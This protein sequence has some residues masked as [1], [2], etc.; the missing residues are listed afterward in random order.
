[1][2]QAYLIL[3]HVLLLCLIAKGATRKLFAPPSPAAYDTPHYRLELS[4]HARKDSLVPTNA[5]V[6]LGDSHI[7]GMLTTAVAEPSV[8]FG[9]GGDTTDGIINRL[10][11]YECLARA[12][13]VV[14]LVGINDMVFRSNE[15]ALQNYSALLGA[16]PKGK[17]AAIGVLPVREGALT[18]QNKSLNN[19][20]ISAFN[21]ELQTICKAK[22]IRYIEPPTDAEYESDGVHLSAS[23]YAVFVR[24]LQ[25]EL[26]RIGVDCGNNQI[27]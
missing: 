26:G 19:E 3:L 22:G 5:V 14:L 21:A 20:R 24:H 15:E 8:N 7:E 2:R 1:M 16:L 13:A 6:F 25:I 11:R 23:G 17:T 10:R 9:I 18:E 4:F 27:R 12:K